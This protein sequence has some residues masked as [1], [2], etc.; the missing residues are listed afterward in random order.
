MKKRDGIPRSRRRLAAAV[1]LIFAASLPAQTTTLARM[2]LGQMSR[3]AKAIVRARCVANSTMMES[4]EIWTRT[5]FQVEEIWH[6]MALPG[7]ITVR[8]L[9]GAWGNI[10]SSVSGVPRFRAGEEAV[11]FLE[12]TKRGDF[13]IVSWQQGTFR[14][15][16]V[17]ST[18][19]EV[20]VQDSAF[21]A[22][23]DPSS[24]RFERE[25]VRGMSV[26]E[27][28]GQVE[29]AAASSAGRTP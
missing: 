7:Q 29:A 14:I 8:L 9:G 16:G 5:T 26:V 27:F 2:S 18:G 21:Y 17:A 22:T 19:G 3:S 15:R 20:V 24:Q 6:G 4:D 1:L 25:G 10:T 28:R 23:Y 12:P 11:L 13:S